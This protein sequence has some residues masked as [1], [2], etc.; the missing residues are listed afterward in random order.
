MQS[1]P[2]RVFK[3]ALN[4]VTNTL[5]HN[6]NLFLRKKLSS[7]QCQLC[8]KEQSLHQLLT[9][10]YNDRHNKV[11]VYIHSFLSSHLLQDSSISVD[12]P[13]RPY[14]FPQNMAVTDDIVVWNAPSVHKVEPTILFETGI[15]EAASQKQTKYAELVDHCRQNGFHAT[16]ITVEVASR[17]FIHVPSFAELYK[18]VN[19][20]SKTRSEMEREVIHQ[21]IEGSF[22]I[23]CKKTGEKSE[24]IS[25]LHAPLDYTYIN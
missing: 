12:L 21:A 17:G 24:L 6:K 22:H 25:V 23:W 20:S 10:R 11:L 8:S 5:A 2:E 19:A 13:N 14:T 9:R 18:I 3:F 15:E 1:L 16:L 4:A 7:P